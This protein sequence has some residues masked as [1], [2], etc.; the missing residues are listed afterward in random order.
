MVY[1][2]RKIKNKRRSGFRG[3][4][5]RQSVFRAKLN[6]FWETVHEKLVR[7]ICE[8]HDLSVDDI[9][10]QD[11]RIP[12]EHTFDKL[13]DEGYRMKFRSIKSVQTEV[14]NEIFKE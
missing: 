12:W 11:E 2:N 8:D 6:R 5:K 7:Q 14:E 4:K 13:R 10:V 3:P 9:L 1:H